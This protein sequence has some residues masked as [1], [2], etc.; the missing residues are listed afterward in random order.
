MWT[1]VRVLRL[2]FLGRV[3][4]QAPPLIFALLQALNAIEDGADGG[5]YRSL[6]PPRKSRKMT[7]YQNQYTNC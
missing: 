6:I 1:K 4:A 5:R 3:L 2:N 7:L